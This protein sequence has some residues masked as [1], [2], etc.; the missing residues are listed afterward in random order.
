MHV[1]G[2]ATAAI[3]NEA[4]G[5]EVAEAIAKLTSA[6]HVRLLKA[7]RIKLVGTAYTDARDLYREALITPYAA[8]RGLGGRRWPKDVD[9]MTFLMKTIQ[10]IASDSRKSAE[11]R[12]TRPL[13]DNDLGRQDIPANVSPSTEEV[14]EDEQE[15]VELQYRSEINLR[16]VCDYFSSKPQVMSI[17]NGMQDGKSPSEIQ[18][19]SGMSKTQYESARRALRRGLE[20][21]FPERKES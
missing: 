3:S 14:V 15:A 9:F 1:V 16:R 13:C 6:D 4:T 11:R 17:I 10:G 2:A 18:E 21:L 7:A 19:S 8:A 5:V 12:Q 20:K